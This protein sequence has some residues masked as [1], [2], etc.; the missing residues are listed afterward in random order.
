MTDETGLQWL[1][2]SSSLAQLVVWLVYHPLIL[3]GYGSHLT[4]GFDKACKDD[5]ILPSYVTS[6]FS[7]L[8][9]LEVD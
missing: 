3:D 7:S 8:G 5:D 2:K 4:P 9:P 1:Q 6:I